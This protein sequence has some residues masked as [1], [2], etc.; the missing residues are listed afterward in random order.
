MS[1]FQ[2]IVLIV[3]ISVPVLS[4]I[5]SS[6]HLVEFFNLGN[7]P[8]ISIILAVAF[9]LGSI[10]SFLALGLLKNVNKTM[11]WVIFSILVFMQIIG[12]VYYSFNYINQQLLID[13]NWIKSAIE[14]LSMFGIYVD[15]GKM[16]LSTL[17]GLPI[18]LISLFFLKSTSDYLNDIENND[19]DDN[20]APFLNN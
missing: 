6:I 17:I 10:A 7:E 1:L 4:S 5:I 13:T 11:L 14:F 2:K 8:W 15:E 3:F 18:P 9:E 20:F 19:V 12:N 16:I